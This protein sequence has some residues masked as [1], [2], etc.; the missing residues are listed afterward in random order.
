MDDLIL[1]IASNPSNIACLESYVDKVM[2]EFD[3]SKDLYANMLISLT[4]AVNNA[5]IHG[6]GCDN[7][8]Y[9]HIYIKRTSD[10]VSFEVC[11]EG[12]GFD[13]EAIPDPTTRENIT[14]EGGRGVF[15][16][17]QLCDKVKFNKNGS[18]I[19]LAFYTK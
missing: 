8:K 2:G 14:H 16:I 4:E 7:S 19:E 9:V 11:D 12:K 5:I 1:K 13:P 18:S 6:N 17:R 3:I 10:R 15:L